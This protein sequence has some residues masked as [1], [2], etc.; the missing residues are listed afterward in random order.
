LSP[1]FFILCMK[2]VY[3][4]IWTYLNQSLNHPRMICT[5]FNQ[6]WLAASGKIKIFQVKEKNQCIFTVLLL[7][8]LAKCSSPKDDLCQAELVEIG[9]VR[10]D[11]ANVKSFDRFIYY[12]HQRTIM[13]QAQLNWL[14]SSRENVAIM[15]SVQSDRL[16]QQTLS[17]QKTS[18]ELR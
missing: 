18:F 9:R 10:K 13:W 7:S 5:M 3:F 11:V 14:I 12:I 17:D 4:S 2:E 6:N 15:K 16:G 8:P 1:Y